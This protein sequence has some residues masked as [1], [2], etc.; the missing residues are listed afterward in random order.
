MYS[1]S[2]GDGLSRDM[3]EI[4]VDDFSY[5]IDDSLYFLSRSEFSILA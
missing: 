1:F 5:E 3:I 4:V 2:V